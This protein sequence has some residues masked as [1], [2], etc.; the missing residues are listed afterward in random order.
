MYRSRSSCIQD[1]SVCGHVF[2]RGSALNLAFR[3]YGCAKE[4]QRWRRLFIKEGEHK[5]TSSTRCSTRDSRGHRQRAVV[6]ADRRA[7][8]SSL[9]REALTTR[10]KNV[11]AIPLS[12]R[13]F[14]PLPLPPHHGRSRGQPLL[15]LY[16]SVHVRLSS[17]IARRACYQW[18]YILFYA[19]FTGHDIS[20]RQLWHRYGGREPGAPCDWTQIDRGRPPQ[21]HMDAAA[22]CFV[23]AACGNLAGGASLTIDR[24]RGSTASERV[25][26]RRV[27]PIHT[28]RVWKCSPKESMLDRVAPVQVSLALPLISARE[29]HVC[30]IQQHLIFIARSFSKILSDR[31][32]MTFENIFLL[33]YYSKKIN[34]KYSIVERYYWIIDNN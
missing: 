1:S 10:S 2:A 25:R 21:P 14:F 19:R 32:E 11:A 6:V 15:A 33:V 34:G 26:S 12:D 24:R 8:D 29:I 4:T 18:R 30:E 3:R 28:S 23:E 9:V 17:G 16:F 20:M 31:K 22:R 5:F 7:Q 13:F 27:A